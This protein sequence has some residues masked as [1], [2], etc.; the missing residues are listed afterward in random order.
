[1]KRDTRQDLFYDYFNLHQVLF[2]CINKGVI[3]KDERNKE[4]SKVKVDIE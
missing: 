2:D 4:K 3:L 1:M